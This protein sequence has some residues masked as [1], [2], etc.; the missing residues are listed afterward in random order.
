MPAQPKIKSR[1]IDVYYTSTMTSCLLCDQP[2][3]MHCSRCQTAHYCSRQCQ[4]DHWSDHKRMCKGT[5]V[6][7]SAKIEAKKQWH[8]RTA[9]HAT[10]KLLGNIC[11]MMAWY[12]SP[13]T[14]EVNES[15]DAFA[16][17]DI[18]RIVHLRPGLPGAI[19]WQS[20]GNA[21][22]NTSD[23]VNNVSDCIAGGNSDSNSGDHQRKVIFSFPECEITIPVNQKSELFDKLKKTH[24]RPSSCWNVAF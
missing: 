23:S 19:N 5:V 13:I 4:V 2:A 11:L 3:S 21:S 16:K 14:I 22:G 8:I 20:T 1:T 9:E 10:S 18:L 15:A 17:T 7:E 12:G 6:S 24:P